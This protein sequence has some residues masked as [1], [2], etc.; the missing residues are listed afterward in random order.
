MKKSI[1]SMICLILGAFALLG[2]VAAINTEFC[3]AYRANAYGFISDI[4]GKLT[5]SI[6]ICIGEVF[7]LIFFLLLIILVLLL[8]LFL[9]FKNKTGYRM[10]FFCYSKMMILLCLIVVFVYTCT[11]SIPFRGSVV[12][13]KGA[14][15][16][17]Y[18]L[19]EVVNVRAHIV[20]KIN[21]LSYSVPRDENG[22]VIYD[23]KK[24]KSEIVYSMKKLGE[25]YPLLK[26]YYP[27]MKKAMISDVLE[28]MDIAGYTY[29]YTMEVTYNK[30]STDLY[31]PFL[32]AHE[33][34]H[35][36]GY[37]K[38]SEANFLAFLACINSDDVVSKYSGYIEIYYYLNDA[39]LE[40]VS[41]NKEMLEYLKTHD[42]IREQVKDDINEA[43]KKSEELY[44]KDD[45][46]G[47]KFSESAQK[48]SKVGWEAQDEV[49]KE[50]N[51]DGVVKM[52]LDFYDVNYDLNK[53]F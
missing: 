23:N 30:Y 32:F 42:L 45:H 52:V 25:Q 26:G 49:L 12:K 31:Y 6:P 34:S 3:D 44:N 10:V 27:P 24:S 2:N 50:D 1:Y 40:K 7:M 17:D 11:W 29:P 18:K 8:V 21:E 53:G 38:E 20:K 39:V 13:V 16:R 22:K 43:L 28:W 4:F 37:Y 47:Q 46:P 5:A 19:G 9:I 51:Y 15:D 35:H 41:N 33:S 14:V 48:A 36:Q